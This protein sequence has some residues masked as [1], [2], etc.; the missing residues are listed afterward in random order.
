[1]ISFN[2]FNKSVNIN[3][4]PNVY[5]FAEESG[6]GKTRLY[7]ALVSISNMKLGNV[8]PVTYKSDIISKLDDVIKS[9]Q[10]DIILFDRFD[11]YVSAVNIEELHKSQPN[12]VIL[13][14]WKHLP[15]V[16]T[17]YIGYCVVE[18]TSEGIIVGD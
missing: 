8:L 1:M 13:L 17:F 9:Q 18:L 7:H 2:I 15:M 11:K 14:D 10:F 5:A 12:A 3:L 6:C 16:P 4:E